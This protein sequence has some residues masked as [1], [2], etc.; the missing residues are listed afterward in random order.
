M[1][2]FMIPTLNVNIFCWEDCFTNLSW[3]ILSNDI[4]VIDFSWLWN[5]HSLQLVPTGHKYSL[6]PMFLHFLKQ[7]LHLWFLQNLIR[8]Q[9]KTIFFLKLF[10]R[11][12]FFL[13]SRLQICFFSTA[14]V[15]GWR[16]TKKRHVF[17]LP[18]HKMDR[19]LKKSIFIF[20]VKCSVSR[21]FSGN[22]RKK[23]KNIP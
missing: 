12:I 1:S 23:K 19:Y 3:T 11:N 10:V 7:V 9:T 2:V 22:H 16:G 14:K 18:R 13:L 4:T 17:F 6:L 5:Y 21:N 20:R 8:L 15:S